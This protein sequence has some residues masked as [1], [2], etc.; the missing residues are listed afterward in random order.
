M[1]NWQDIIRIEGDKTEVQPI[2]DKFFTTDHG[3][4]ILSGIKTHHGTITLKV[5]PL[6]YIETLKQKGE[7]AVVVAGAQQTSPHVGAG[8]DPFKKQIDFYP[9]DFEQ[10]FKYLGAD[11]K[12]RLFTKERGIIHEIQH[13][14][15]GH[16]KQAVYLVDA[17]LKAE[18][19]AIWN[20]N[21]YLQTEGVPE[22]ALVYQGATLADVDISGLACTLPSAKPAQ[23]KER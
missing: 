21:A 20:T 11:G 14:G 23:H 4:C 22:R 15:L 17:R 5:H 10:G 6:T 9:R 18:K 7:E 3:Q 2:L 13:A 8:F 12:L 1:A 19:G 16:D